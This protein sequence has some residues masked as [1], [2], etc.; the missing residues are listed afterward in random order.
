MATIPA[1][2]PKLESS[3]QSRRIL[4]R[5]LGLLRPYLRLTVSAYAALLGT[6]AIVLVT[7][8]FLR[9]IV[10]QGIRQNDMQI[11]TWAVLGLLALS[12]LRGALTFASGLMAE[13]A[14]QGV[15]YDL[16]RDLHDKLTELS[17]AY[18]DRT[19]SGQLL[20]RMMQD[21]ERL[22]M[23]TGRSILGLANAVVLLIGTAA[24]LFFMNPTLAFLLCSQCRYW[25]TELRFSAHATGPCRSRFSSSWPC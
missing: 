11:L 3:N 18:H 22:R 13:N 21:V 10:D 20:S 16:R 4:W 14:S 5:S 1:D 6:T 2:L 12:A 24:A 8:Q 15:S 17:F 9:W 23:L 7:P 25:R 19:E